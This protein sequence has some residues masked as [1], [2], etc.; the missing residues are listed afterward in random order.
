MSILNITKEEKLEVLIR[1]L[2]SNESF[3]IACSKSGLSSF[4][5]KNLLA[6]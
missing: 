3:E 5:A 4:D 2:K 6:Q 1:L